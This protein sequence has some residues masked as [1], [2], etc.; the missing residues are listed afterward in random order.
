MVLPTVLLHRVQAKLRV[1]MLF[2]FDSGDVVAIA[3]P[4]NDT[5]PLEEWQT[6]DRWPGESVE[7]LVVR[8]LKQETMH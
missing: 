4:K 1:R 8:G 6:L 2:Q 3:V 5:D 7:H